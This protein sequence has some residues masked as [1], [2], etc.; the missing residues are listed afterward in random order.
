MIIPTFIFESY[1]SFRLYSIYMKTIFSIYIKNYE[2]LEIS[3][4]QHIPDD[5][6]N[7]LSLMFKNSCMVD[8]NAYLEDDILYIITDDCDEYEFL[9]SLYNS[10]SPQQPQNNIV[11]VKPNEYCID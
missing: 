8:F 1:N 6:F 4:E 10:Q 3:S 7:S 5:V 11:I 2:T 9:Y